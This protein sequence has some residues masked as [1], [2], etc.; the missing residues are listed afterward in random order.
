MVTIGA[1]AFAIAYTRSALA[2]LDALRAHLKARV[3]D[4]IHR[5][6]TAAPQTP[7]TNRKPLPGAHPSFAHTPPLWELRVG[8]HR[9]FYDVDEAARTVYVRAIRAKG[10]RTTGEIL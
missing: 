6:L 4:A 7:A 10:R 3:A 5:A 9:V 2:E 1:V 8:A